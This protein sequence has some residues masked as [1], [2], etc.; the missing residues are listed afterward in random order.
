MMTITSSGAAIMDS[1][2]ASTFGSYYYFKKDLNG[3]DVYRSPG[4]YYLYFDADDDLW[5]VSNFLRIKA[6]IY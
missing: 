1:W 3:N 5:S 4:G 2:A 6:H